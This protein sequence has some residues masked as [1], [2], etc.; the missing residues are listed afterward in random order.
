MIHLPN[1]ML[2]FLILLGDSSEARVARASHYIHAGNLRSAVEELEAVSDP[3]TAAV[4]SDW[5]H[6]AK[7]RLLLTQALETVRSH[8]STLS[9]S[10]S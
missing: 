2:T 4:I 1:G 10:L 3:A 9:A 8:V 7:A 6:D 5:L